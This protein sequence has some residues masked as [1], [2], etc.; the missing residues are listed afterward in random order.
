MVKRAAL[1]VLA[2]SAVL[3][4]LVSPVAAGAAGPHPHP[5]AA[6]LH[7]TVIPPNVCVDPFVSCLIHETGTISG[8]L[9][10]P[11]TVT[12]VR[13]IVYDPIPGPGCYLTGT[14][15][16]TL[17]IVARSGGELYV[18]STGTF[19]VVLGVAGT[20]TGT[21]TIASGTGRFAGSSG[22]GSYTLTSDPL[23]ANGVAHW[24][25]VVA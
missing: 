14:S 15:S 8:S 12:V 13:N 17:T 19:C 18:T 24:T 6:T 3:G 7:E 2:L 22:T 1:A 11:G 21:L 10:G 5:F 16:E 20:E 25:G 4:G 23:S 9:T